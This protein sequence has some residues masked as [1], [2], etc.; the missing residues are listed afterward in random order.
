MKEIIADAQLVAPCGLY[1]GAC[2]RYLSGG[3]QG[4]VADAKKGWCKIRSCCLENKYASCADCKI[5]ADCN[6]CKKFNNFISRIFQF[7]FRSDRHACIMRIKAIGCAKFAEEMA[8]AKLLTI[9]CKP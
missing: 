9:K 7:I 6:N 5:F 4:C 8:K 1:C 3:C 2:K